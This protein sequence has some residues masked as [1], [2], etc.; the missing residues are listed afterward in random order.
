M[1]FMYTAIHFEREKS[2]GVS[3][4]KHPAGRVNTNQRRASTL[5]FRRDN[6]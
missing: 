5:D 4:C 6:L 2:V 1:Y 3:N